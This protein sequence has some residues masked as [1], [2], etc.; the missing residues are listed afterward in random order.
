MHHLSQAVLAAGSLQGE[1]VSA[2]A[3]D[4]GENRALRPVEFV[5]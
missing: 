3:V 1:T 5:T 4:L 2:E